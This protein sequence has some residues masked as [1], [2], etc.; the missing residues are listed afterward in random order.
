MSNSSIS[1]FRRHRAVHLPGSSLFV[2]GRANARTAGGAHARAAACTGAKKVTRNGWSLWGILRDAELRADRGTV[3]DE[4][5]GI[6]GG[7]G[8]RGGWRI[9]S[10]AR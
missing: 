9:V 10:Q 7:L 2:S 5:A 3:P 6:K 1:R 8:P 4:F